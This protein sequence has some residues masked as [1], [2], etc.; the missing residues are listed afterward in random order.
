MMQR[1]QSHG[2]IVS[3]TLLAYCLASTNARAMTASLLGAQTS[4][5]R[6]YFSSNKDNRFLVRVHVL[7]DVALSGVH[8]VPDNLSL[9]DLIGYAGGPNG[10]FADSII[11]LNRKATDSN[12]PEE[13]RMDGQTLVQKVELR[14]L[15][16]HDGD[17]VYMEAP[18]T[19][20]FLRTLTIV[21][22]ILGIIS[23]SATIYLIT[24]K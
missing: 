1:L 19:E 5:E 18:R 9:L 22:T 24:K 3:L 21:S 10:S 12:V 23:T 15:K 14:D 13:I 11:T 4:N 7:G 6:E 8:H 20:S 17:V 2:R 16:V